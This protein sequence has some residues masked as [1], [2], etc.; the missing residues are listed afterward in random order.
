MWAGA[1][2]QLEDG[3]H[4]LFSN[5]KAHGIPV[6]TLGCANRGSESLRNT[7]RWTL[8]PDRVPRTPALSRLRPGLLSVHACSQALSMEP[9]NIQKLGRG[10]L[11]KEVVLVSL[12]E[13]Q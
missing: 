2:G 7:L 3:V 9:C 11:E 4:G 1:D 12:M 10:V 13:K 8:L 6:L 5:R